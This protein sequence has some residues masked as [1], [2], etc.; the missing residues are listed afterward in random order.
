MYPDWVWDIERPRKTHHIT[1]AELATRLGWTRGY[2]SKIINGRMT[3]K[4][5]EARVK[6]ALAEIIAERESKQED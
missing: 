4:N 1:T 3:P 2:L 6:A 5:A